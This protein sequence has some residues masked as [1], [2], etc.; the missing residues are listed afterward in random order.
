MG[1]N[2]TLNITD[3]QYF[4]YG[5]INRF[6]GRLKTG[7]FFSQGLTYGDSSLSLTLHAQGTT[8]FLKNRFTYT[9]SYLFGNAVEDRHGHGYIQER[10]TDQVRR[11]GGLKQTI[12]Y[13]AGQ[14]E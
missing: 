3:M 11:R 7:G 6:Y 4:Y 9:R 8:A 12:G 5:N 1:F 13:T 10:H 2:G 14:P